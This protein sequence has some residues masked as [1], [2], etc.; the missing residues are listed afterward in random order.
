MLKMNLTLFTFAG[1][2]LN[3]PITGFYTKK[4]IYKL[5][6]NQSQDIEIQRENFL[7]NQNFTE[8]QQKMI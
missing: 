3:I 6:D 8:I 7:F 4:M 5:L 2:R 1:V